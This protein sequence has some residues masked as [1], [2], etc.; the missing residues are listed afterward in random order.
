M[1]YGEILRGRMSVLAPIVG[2]IYNPHS[3]E[4][5][6]DLDVLPSV[7]RELDADRKRRCTSV[8]IARLALNTPSE[9]LFVF[10][11]VSTCTIP[12]VTTLEVVI[13][14]TVHPPNSQNSHRCVESTPLSERAA[15]WDLGIAL[16]RDGSGYR[17]T[18]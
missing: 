12:F 14:W 5:V 3:H 7:L 1:V 10:F 17:L 16:V 6:N 11:A 15:I 2:D 4:M 8:L 9:R 18:H 13:Q